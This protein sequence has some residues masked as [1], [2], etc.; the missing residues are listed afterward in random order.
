MKYL[1]TPGL[2][3][4][5]TL[6]GYIHGFSVIEG[7]QVSSVIALLINPPVAD[8]WAQHLPTDARKDAAWAR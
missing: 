2:I 8:M 3:T 1:S 6:S 5:R 7:R 4:S